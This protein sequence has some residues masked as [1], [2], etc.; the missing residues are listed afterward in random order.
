MHSAVTASLKP[1]VHHFYVLLVSHHQSVS[2]SPT[3]PLWAY[4][5][6]TLRLQA[7]SSQAGIISF[8][9]TIV[10]QVWHKL[11]V[12]PLVIRGF[13]FSS[14]CSMLSLLK[15]NICQFNRHVIVIWCKLL[16]LHILL[17]VWIFLH[18]SM[19]QNGQGGVTWQHTWYIVLNHLNFLLVFS[20]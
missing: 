3:G 5:T 17:T 18:V 1:S 9:Y 12:S 14:F 19:F 15:P 4:H 10:L 2:G 20:S 16:G 8:C 6:F 7:H 13:L 11:V